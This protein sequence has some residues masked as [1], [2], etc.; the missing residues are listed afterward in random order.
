MLLANSRNDVIQKEESRRIQHALEHLEKLSSEADVRIRL[1][2]ISFMIAS[3][4]ICPI[5]VLRTFLPRLQFIHVFSI[6]QSVSSRDQLSGSKRES[7]GVAT[8]YDIAILQLLKPSRLTSR[9]GSDYFKTL[10]GRRW[11]VRTSLSL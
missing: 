2:S 7:S 5:L 1:T 9:C 11:V 3:R 4:T 8:R 10:L 6:S